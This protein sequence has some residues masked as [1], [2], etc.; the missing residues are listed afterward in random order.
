M[1]EATK[2]SNSR[3]IRIDEVSKKTGKPRSGIYA[4][5]AE[6]SFPAP[7]K[8]SHRCSAWPEEEVDEWISK[9]INERNLQLGHLHA[10]GVV[11]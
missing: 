2:V 6:G 8:I 1:A 7:V 5:I 4:A 10:G 3:L 9:R 11:V